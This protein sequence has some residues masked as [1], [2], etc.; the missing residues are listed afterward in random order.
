MIKKT[1]KLLVLT[2]VILGLSSCYKSID[3][4]DIDT[5]DLTLTYYDKN[6]AESP[7]ENFQ[8][9]KTFVIRD[10]VGIISDYLTQD[11][12]D[13]FWSPTG[14]GPKIRS[15]IR[16][17]FIEKG[18]QQVDSLKNAD[19]AINIVL[20]LVENTTYTMYPGW[21]YGWDGYWGWYGY[22]GYYKNANNSNYYDYWWGG[23]Y[24]YYP[25]YG[26]SSYTYETGTIMIE[27]IDARSLEELYDF[28]SDKTPD[29]IQDNLDSIPELKY[30]WQAFL[31]GV[32]SSTDSYNEDRF[33]RGV[34]EAFEQS[35][36]I[37]AK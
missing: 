15:Y 6:F 23:Y 37:H 36:Y 9:Y 19:F 12:K 30:R 5:Q 4:G 11:E 3:T 34:D 17:K 8:T 20:E 22:Y 29:E 25:S 10:S 35:P 28:V 13:K 7:T 33:N 16:K 18:Y 2:L 1:H 24:P 14:N 27:M 31:N 21:W 26:Y 32:V